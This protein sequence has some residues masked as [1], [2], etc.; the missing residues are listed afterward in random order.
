MVRLRKMDVAKEA[1]QRVVQQR[2]KNARTDMH[3]FYPLL[4]RAERTGDC[5][6][7]QQKLA[8]LAK[9]RPSSAPSLRHMVQHAT[10]LSNIS[11]S[12][13]Q[14]PLSPSAAMLLQHD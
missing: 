11:E 9:K 4:A 13:V 3:K 14:K 5:S 7:L 10:S 6:E 2:E 8:T 12:S 1:R